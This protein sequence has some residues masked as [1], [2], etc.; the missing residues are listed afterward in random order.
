V[1]DIGRRKKELELLIERSHKQLNA[2]GKKITLRTS[3]EYRY[4]AKRDLEALASVEDMITIL[5]NN[6]DVE[7]LNNLFVM[8]PAGMK[9]VERII[10]PNRKEV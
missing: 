9:G 5:L 3:Q 10:Y 2:H 6:F 8:S 7:K 1:R 4:Q